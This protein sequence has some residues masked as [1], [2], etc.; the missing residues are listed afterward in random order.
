MFE[1]AAPITGPQSAEPPPLDEETAARVR[2]VLLHLESKLKAQRGEWALESVDQVLELVRRSVFALE[3]GKKALRTKLHNFWA[4]P[5][6]L[7]A[8]DSGT[9]NLILARYLRELR[10][11]VPGSPLCSL[12]VCTNSR[13]IF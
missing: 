3:S 10:L 13:R 2:A 1:Q 4:E 9:T 8:I 11:P 5:F 7:V 6:R 12:T